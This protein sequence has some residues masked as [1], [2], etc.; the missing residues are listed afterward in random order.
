MASEICGK[1]LSYFYFFADDIVSQ[2]FVSSSFCH[3]HADI[4]LS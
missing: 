1:I 2:I 4:I 3:I